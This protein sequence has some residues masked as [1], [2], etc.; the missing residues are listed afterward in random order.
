MMTVFNAKRGCGWP[1]SFAIGCV[2]SLLAALALF[3]GAAGTN[4]TAETVE[5]YAAGSLRTTVEALAR[6]VAATADIDVKP[7]FGGSGTLRQRIEAGE[8]P[9]LF[10]S[11]DMAAPRKLADA[12]RT[13]VPV[14]PFARNRMCL[15]ARRSTGLTPE[16]LTDIMLAK[17]LRLKTSMPVADPGGDYAMAIFDRID[18]VRRG[19]GQILRDKAQ[20]QMTTM[21][22]AL[23]GHSAGAA[24]FLGNQIDLMVTYCSGATALASEVP[25]LATV[26][27]PPELTPEPIYGMAV[28]SMKPGALRL[29]LFLLSEKGQAIVAEAGLLPIIEAA[30]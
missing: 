25:E 7:T 15:V 4:A 9:D 3:A 10:L 12:A 1:R 6:H 30:R 13:L 11:A 5:V 27:F 28:L 16:N 22:A 21:P 23:A 29:A 26:A 2:R 17:D 14:V 8:S 24:L 18:G 20:A 19:A